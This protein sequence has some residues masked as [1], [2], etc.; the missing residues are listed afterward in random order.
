MSKK[1]HHGQ[2]WPFTFKED[3]RQRQE[4]DGVMQINSHARLYP[5]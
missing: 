3:L 5:N 2:W 1:G 4:L